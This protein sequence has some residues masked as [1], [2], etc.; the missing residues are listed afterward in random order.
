MSTTSSLSYVY[1]GRRCIGHV[2]GR[3]NTGF[4]AFNTDDK[5]LGLFPSMKDAATACCFQAESS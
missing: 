4:E 3:G 1:D 5:S 2:I